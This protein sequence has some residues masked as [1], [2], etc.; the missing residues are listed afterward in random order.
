MKDFPMLKAGP[1]ADPEL[2]DAHDRLPEAQRE[3][4]G[5]VAREVQATDANDVIA[6]PSRVSQHVVLRPRAVGVRL[7]RL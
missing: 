4:V 5:Q 6:P 7:A 2:I 3:R 1:P